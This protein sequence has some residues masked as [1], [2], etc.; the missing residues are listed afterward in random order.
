MIVDFRLVAV[1]A[2]AGGILEGMQKLI[3]FV[4]RQPVVPLKNC[5]D[6]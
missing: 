3:L 6:C 4:Q 5:R 1:V 2:I